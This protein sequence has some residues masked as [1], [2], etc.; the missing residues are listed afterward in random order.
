MNKQITNNTLKRIHAETLQLFSKYKTLEI[1]YT[2]E[3]IIIKI[4]N[5]DFH[6]NNKYPFNP[7]SVYINSIPYSQY[8][9]TKSPKIIKIIKKYIKNDCLCCSTIICSSNWSATYHIQ[10]LMDEIEH[11]NDVK[12][13]VKYTIAINEIFNK[14][15]I[16]NDLENTVL[17]YLFITA[18]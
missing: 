17:E 5:V 1:K 11:I 6:I 8:L 13:I 18:L 2:E 3:H 7:P 10:K 15:K 16:P 12:R 9:I 14:K 4:N